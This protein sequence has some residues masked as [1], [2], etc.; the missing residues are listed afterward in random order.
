MEP[1]EAQALRQ[2]AAEAARRK[3][4]RGLDYE[5]HPKEIVCLPQVGDT[6]L[7]VGIVAA[8]LWLHSLSGV[9]TEW[10]C[11]GEVV[12]RNDTYRP[13]VI[14]YCDDPVTVPE[15]L[16]ILKDSEHG[17]S[18]SPTITCGYFKTRV[19]VE[20]YNGRVRYVLRW[21]DRLSLQSFMEWLS[22]K[23]PH[24]R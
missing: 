10:S 23:G 1:H 22:Q 12:P 5:P 17:L 15:V 19:E 3:P 16:R 4:Y 2:L 13:Y 9:T 21:H 7:D 11:Q 8:V 18:G 14:F 20:W 24:P 6:E